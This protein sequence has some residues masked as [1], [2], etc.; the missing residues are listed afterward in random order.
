MQ[1]H[2]QNI[3]FIAIVGVLLGCAFFFS[4]LTDM[5]GTDMVETDS[6][7]ETKKSI[8]DIPE[9]GAAL[10]DEDALECYLEAAQIAD[11]LVQEKV[12]QIL[13]IE[14]ESDYRMAFIEMQQAWEDSRDADCE[15]IRQQTN[16]NGQE[17]DKAERCLLEHNLGRLTQLEEI[18]C[19]WYG[20]VDCDP[21][22]MSLP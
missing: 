1:R 16:E 3:S 20:D 13:A 6:P 15:F 19:E 12:E 22:Q 11:Q 14:T 8:A 5:D 7:P 21:S 2:M 4:Q 9:C 10:T 18:Y 17:S